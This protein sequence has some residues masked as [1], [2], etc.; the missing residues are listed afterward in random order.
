M[1]TLILPYQQ[2]AFDKWLETMAFV[3]GQETKNNILLLPPQTGTGFVKAMK[4]QPGLSFGLGNF[5]FS[6]DAH[7]QVKDNGQNGY[8]LYFRKLEINESY[9]FKMGDARKES[10][11]ESYETALLISSRMDHSIEFKKGTYVKSLAIYIEEEWIK[12]NVDESNQKKL[13]EYVGC[14]ICNYNKEVLSAKHKKILETMLREDLEIPLSNLFLQSRVLR[15]VEYFLNAVLSRSDK[16]LPVFISE[17]D[18]KKL[19]QVENVLTQNYLHE[20]PSIEE[21][22]KLALMSE[23][24][25]KKLFKHI[26]KMGLYEYYQKNRMHRAKEILSSGK[27]KISEIGTML[28]YANLSNFSVAFKKEFG[29]LPSEYKTSFELRA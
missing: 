29:Y 8:L 7:L 13:E 21:M 16:D 4:V 1:E 9:V 18:L 26:F 10:S 19:T 14:G 3:L 5:C 15:M 28:G 2:I 17:H 23:T 12:Q 25:L 24:K 27:Y 11:E 20:F 22:A 6:T